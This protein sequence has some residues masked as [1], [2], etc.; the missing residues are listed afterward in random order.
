MLTHTLH[1]YHFVTFLL[2][3][4][5]FTSNVV[6][7]QRCTCMMPGE[8]FGITRQHKPVYSSE[9]SPQETRLQTEPSLFPLTQPGLFSVTSGSQSKACASLCTPTVWNYFL[10]NIWD[11]DVS[12]LILEIKVEFKCSITKLSGLKLNFTPRVFRFKETGR[13]LHYLNEWDGHCKEVLFGDKLGNIKLL[14]SNGDWWQLGHK[15]SHKNSQESIPILKS[16]CSLFSANSRHTTWLSGFWFLFHLYAH[17]HFY[18]YRL[19]SSLR[20]NACGLDGAAATVV[21]S[22]IAHTCPVE[23]VKIKT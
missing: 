7:L 23:Y 17:F 2:L 22:L 1:W 11:A 10:F 4:D 16:S 18:N 8:T 13:V 15:N 14:T 12:S 9:D 5:E 3:Q 20:R 19:I 6:A 21:K